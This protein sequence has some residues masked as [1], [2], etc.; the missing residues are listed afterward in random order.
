[1]NRSGQRLDPGATIPRTRSGWAGLRSLL[2]EEVMQEAILFDA[3][4]RRRSP[5]TLPGYLSGRSPHKG[6]AVSGGSAAG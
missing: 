1:M 2:K 5:V 6:H 3:A 4:G